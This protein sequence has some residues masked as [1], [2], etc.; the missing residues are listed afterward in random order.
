LAP[1]IDQINTEKESADA[2][3][4]TIIGTL[5]KGKL[6]TYQKLEELKP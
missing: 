3:F 5:T 2:N 4:Y 6:H 1:K